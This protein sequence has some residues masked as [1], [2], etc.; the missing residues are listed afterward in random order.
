[1]TTLNEVSSIKTNGNADFYVIQDAIL[2]LNEK[3]YLCRANEFCTEVLVQQ[4][5][6]TF[7]QL[8]DMFLYQTDNKLIWALQ[9]GAS[10]LVYES[11]L[12]FDVY[13]F[14]ETTLDGYG[15]AHK[16]MAGDYM[17][18]S[19][20]FISHEKKILETPEI[21]SFKLKSDRGLHITWAK[22]Y[23]QFYNRERNPH[24]RIQTADFCKKGLT[25]G[26]AN[27]TVKGDAV[28]GG[29]FIYFPLDNDE[30][31]ALS[32]LDGAFAWS[33]KPPISN[34][35]AF[36]GG[37]LYAC[38]SIIQEIDGVTGR[39]LRT[40]N[41]EDIYPN[42]FNTVG[43]S[44]G[45]DDFIVMQDPWLGKLLFIDNKKLAVT[46]AVE[47]E[48]GCRFINYDKSLKRMNNRIF[49][50]DNDYKIRIYELPV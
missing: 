29:E 16:K 23:V 36:A 13:L 4:E 10:E 44:W 27:V 37:N 42:A 46:H 25:G 35:Y 26:N 33:V 41:I 39:L 24:L 40:V 5:V 21:F 12:D 8:G 32:I 3:G 47:L 14:G 45:F 6:L 7:S 48:A 2:F 9:N 22:S 11:G 19:T 15:F 30:V 18:H 50:L 28:T 38:C 20:I 49:I 34:H 1:M 17:P 31:A 43:R